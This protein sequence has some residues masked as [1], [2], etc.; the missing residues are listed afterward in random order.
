M[1][2]PI[3]IGSAPDASPR[4]RFCS[5]LGQGLRPLLGS[6]VGARFTPGLQQQL[7]R[8]LWQ[9][10]AGGRRPSMAQLHRR[11]TARRCYQRNSAKPSAAGTRRSV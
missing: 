2:A 6:L 7:G 10:V 8:H 1:T 11:R 3:L 9:F 5:R 4:S